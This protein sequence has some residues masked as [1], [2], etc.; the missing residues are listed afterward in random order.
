MP[1]KVKP[2]SELARPETP[3]VPTLSRQN[4]IRERPSNSKFSNRVPAG[5]PAGSAL[6]ATPSAGVMATAVLRPSTSHVLA[7]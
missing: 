1:S 3:T 5:V 6:P 2:T 7:K 4:V